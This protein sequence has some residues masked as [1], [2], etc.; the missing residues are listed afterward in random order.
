L[1]TFERKTPMTNKMFVMLVD[2]LKMI[3]RAIKSVLHDNEL[4]FRRKKSQEL[5]N[6]GIILCHKT[7]NHYPQADE[8]PDREIQMIKQKIPLD[9]LEGNPFLKKQKIT[10]SLNKYRIEL[11]SIPPKIIIFAYQMQN[12][13][14]ECLEA[15]SEIKRRVKQRPDKY[16]LGLKNGT[17]KRNDKNCF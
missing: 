7:S 10:E 11:Y 14:R 12:K 16:K 5:C 3:R 13:S 17:T 4:Q 15:Y 2:T 8:V 1:D 9:D 6:R